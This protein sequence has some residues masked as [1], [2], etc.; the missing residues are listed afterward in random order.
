MSDLLKRAIAK[1]KSSLSKDSIKEPEIIYTGVT[2]I[3]VPDKVIDVDTELPE[4]KDETRFPVSSKNIPFYNILTKRYIKERFDYVPNLDP[5]FPFLRR[6]KRKKVKRVGRLR[7]DG[8]C[9]VSFKPTITGE[10]R[11]ITMKMHRLVWLHQHKTCYHYSDLPL[12]INHKNGDPADN[13]YTNLEASN[14][15]HNG[16]IWNRNGELNPW[17][18]VYA[19]PS[20]NYQVRVSEIGKHKV[21]YLGTFDSLIQAQLAWDAGMW[22]YNHVSQSNSIDK[23]V[24]CFYFPENKRNYLGKDAWLA[25]Q[26]SIPFTGEGFS[27]EEIQEGLPY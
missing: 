21:I 14:H 9:E 8:Y 17:R 24:K 25:L 22:K 7:P 13:R 12:I 23:L 3:P 1:G 15:S 18:G 2:V 11:K 6:G 10:S 20:G 19:Q 16:S 27:D 26:L 4:A 5:A